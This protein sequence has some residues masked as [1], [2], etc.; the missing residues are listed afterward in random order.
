MHK[1][2]VRKC[3]EVT[4]VNK[5]FQIMPWMTVGAVLVICYVSDATMSLARRI[6]GHQ[7]TSSGNSQ[8]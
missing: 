2:I 8:L 6:Q 5:W 3:W 7:W 1:Q 4:H